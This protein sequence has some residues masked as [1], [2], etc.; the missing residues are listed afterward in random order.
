MKKSILILGL[1]GMLSVQAAERPNFVFIMA[2]DCTFSDIGCY[3]GQA[4]TPHIDGQ[5]TDQLIECHFS[6]SIFSHN[7]PHH[8]L[9][10]HDSFPKVHIQLFVWRNVALQFSLCFCSA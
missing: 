4:K 8:T 6:D 5:K 1:L 7:L 10:S 3:G 9:H 2:D